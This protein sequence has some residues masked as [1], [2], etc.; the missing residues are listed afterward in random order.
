VDRSEQVRR[1]RAVL[2]SDLEE[3]F[4]PGLA[5]RDFAL[6]GVIV[7]A[8]VLDRMVEDRGIGREPGDRKLVDIPAEHTSAQQIP[9]DVVEP[10]TLAQIMQDSSGFHVVT[11]MV[12][13]F[14][15]AAA[16]LEQ[17]NSPSTG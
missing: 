6:D 7:V 14:L 4:F 10:E 5:F 1:L 12:P 8:A 17:L 16:S 2:Q 15:A 3:Q 11:S 9:G 13:G